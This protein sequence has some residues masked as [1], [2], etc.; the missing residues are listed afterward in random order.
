MNRRVQ[1]RIN[2]H[3]NHIR[4]NTSNSS[5]ITDYRLEFNHDFQWNNIEILDNEPIR[6]KRLIS[7]MLFIK[8]QKSSLN[9]QTDTEC[10]HHTYVNVIK[11]SRKFDIR[12]LNVCIQHLIHIHIFCSQDTHHIFKGL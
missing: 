11:N 10:L 9:L 4:W 7:E 12:T 8:N 3:R 2:E 6:N 5:V 1:I